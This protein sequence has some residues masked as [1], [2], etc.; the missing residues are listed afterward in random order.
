MTISSRDL[1]L[2]FQQSG[3]QCAFPNCTCRLTYPSSG[4][5]AAGS[6]SEVAHIVAQSVDGPRGDFPLALEERDRYENLILLC[7]AHHTQ[8]DQQVATF[9]VEKLRQIKYD[10]ENLIAEATRRAAVARAGDQS[11]V[12]NVTEQIY[13]SLLPLERLPRFVFSMEWAG[14]EREVKPRLGGSRAG[15]ASSFI[16]RG[17]RIY[18]FHD[19]RTDPGPFAGLA[20][21]QSIERDD[22][23]SWWKDADRRRWYVDLLN[24]TVNKITGRRSLNLDKEH[25]RY[26]FDQL[27]QDRERRVTYRPMNRDKSEIKVVWRP[28]TKKSGEP[29][30]FWYHRA[31]ALSFVQSGPQS[32]CLALRPEMRV[33]RDGKMPIAAR[34]IGGKVTKKKARMFNIDVLEELNFWRDYLFDGRPRL[35][36]SFGRRGSLVISANFLSAAITWPGVPPESGRSFKNAV[37]EEGL[38]D[39]AEL[40]RLED[41]S[42]DDLDFDIEDLADED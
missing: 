30:K 40:Q 1:R 8:I 5:G 29:K 21:G 12:P 31:I 37:V 6:L 24:R 19:L 34:R 36:T 32:W 27:E 15:E 17:G 11:I 16:V 18:C 3:N 7:P 26:Y 33:T 23:G 9:P 39:L 13:S 14:S 42:D 2:L 4:L 28:V 41:Q 22:A 20:S 35:V 38:F 10:H 25:K